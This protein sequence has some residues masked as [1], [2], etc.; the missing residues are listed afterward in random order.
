MLQTCQEQGC[1]MMRKLSIATIAAIAAL[2]LGGCVSD[3]AYRDGP[4][5]YYYGRPSVDYSYYGYGAPYG[6]IGYGGYGGYG[7]GGYGYGGYSGGGLYGYPYGGY[8]SGY[9]GYYGYPYRNGHYRPRHDGGYER[10]PRP[11]NGSTPTDYNRNVH[12][13]DKI[14]GILERNRNLPRPQPRGISPGGSRQDSGRAPMSVPRGRPGLNRGPTSSI[15]PPP[16]LL[17]RAP[18]MSAPA[19]RPMPQRSMAQRPVMRAQSAPQM[20]TQSRSHIRDFE[21]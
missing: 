4:G 16:S 11:G 5:D 21:R 12:G 15:Q 1:V 3:Y 14:H 8:G 10:P 7:Y 18:Q 20:R 2:L 13:A 6:S 17:G 19:S 9:G